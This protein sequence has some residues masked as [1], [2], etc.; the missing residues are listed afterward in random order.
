MGAAA[1]VPAATSSVAVAASTFSLA[2]PL[3]PTAALLA[4][5]ASCSRKRLL[6]SSSLRWLAC[7]SSGGRIIGGVVGQRPS[8]MRR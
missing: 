1:V 8:V 6:S 3:N 2:A 7:L 4:F 5:S